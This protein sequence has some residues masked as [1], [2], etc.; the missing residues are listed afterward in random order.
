MLT[1]L[2]LIGGPLACTGPPSTTT[3]RPSDTGSTT[4][5]TS[6]TAAPPSTGDTGA[7]PASCAE[8]QA[9]AGVVEFPF[10]DT[11]DTRELAVSLD[12]DGVWL[13]WTAPTPKLGYFFYGS[14]LF[15]GRVRCDGVWDVGPVQLVGAGGFPYVRDPTI[16][17]NAAGLR[18]VWV[19]QE[20]S[21]ARETLWTAVVARDGSVVDAPAPLPLTTGGVP[22]PEPYE[23]QLAALDDGTFALALSARVAPPYLQALLQRMDDGGSVDEALLLA[24]GVGGNQAHVAVA[25]GPGPIAVVWEELVDLGTPIQVG[26]AVVD[27]AVITVDRFEGME[28]D[29]ASVGAGF[30]TTWRTNPAPY[31]NLDAG[32]APAG[33]GD[34]AAPYATD[35][36]VTAGASRLLLTWRDMFGAVE[37]TE[38][39]GWADLTGAPLAEEE[40]HPRGA[41][42]DLRA[43]PLHVGDDLFFVLVEDHATG[44]LLGRFLSPP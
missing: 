28:P 30:A 24:P 4:V 27:G 29:V 23:P 18:V 11:P 31:V 5:P 14:E 36:T 16:A 20:H 35:L 1:L 19:H 9:A 39:L 42:R 7:L 3:P 13:A 40:L 22:L 17:A 33:F 26:R 10:P 8:L 2:P 12:G 41:T 6:D 21:L 34:P 38:R 15:V 25:G 37:D 44:T 43:R 32:G